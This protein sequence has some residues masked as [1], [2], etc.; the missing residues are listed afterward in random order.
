MSAQPKSKADG[1]PLPSAQDLVKELLDKGMKV[2][3]IV[4]ELEGRVSRR[5][6]YRWARGE[7]EPG[8]RRDHSEL[9]ALARGTRGTA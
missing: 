1:E 2:E 7:S 5:T 6:I 9:H 4:E 8:N 3:A